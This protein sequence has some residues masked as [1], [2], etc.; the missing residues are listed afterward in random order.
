MAGSVLDLMTN[1][2]LRQQVKEEHKK[3]LGGQVYKPVGDPDR[4]PPL[5]LARETAEKLKGKQ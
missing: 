1:P 5:E 3:R 2:E 4:E